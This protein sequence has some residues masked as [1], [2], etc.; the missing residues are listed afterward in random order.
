MGG[1]AFGGGA[2]AIGLFLAGYLFLI[3]CFT[4][5]LGL[6]WG[7]EAAQGSATWPYP[8]RYGRLFSAAFLGLLAALGGLPPFFFLGPKLALFS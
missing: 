7:L 3:L 5:V 1:V 2:T 4:A 8:Q 6:G